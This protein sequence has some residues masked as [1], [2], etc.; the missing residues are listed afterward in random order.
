M[1]S[2]VTVQVEPR[3][4]RCFH[5]E[6]KSGETFEI[7]FEVPSTGYLA[8]LSGTLVCFVIQC[9]F[10]VYRCVFVVLSHYQVIR[11]GLL[12]IEF[13]IK[14]PAQTVVFQRLAFFNHKCVCV[15]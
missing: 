10:V 4:E 7:D 14:D 3:S 12:D 2:Y 6:L 11:G 8:P 15:A 9:S 1:G 5:E 13:K